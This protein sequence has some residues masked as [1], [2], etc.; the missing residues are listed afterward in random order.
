[1]AKLYTDEMVNV[2]IEAEEASK[3]NPGGEYIE[4]FNMGVTTMKHY[5]MAKMLEH[6]G[7]EIGKDG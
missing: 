3:L 1:M 5:L 4:C 7:K 2:L 6:D